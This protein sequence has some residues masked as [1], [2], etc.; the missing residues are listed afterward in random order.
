MMLITAEP[1][2]IKR[3]SESRAKMLEHIK[4]PTGRKLFRE[5]LMTKYCEENL[6]FI[7]AVDE[8]KAAKTDVEKQ[9]IAQDIYK[10]HLSPNAT[11]GLCLSPQ[12]EEIVY[13]CRTLAKPNTRTAGPI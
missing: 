4:L 10:T 12:W 9:R 6:D 11:A 2:S 8:L 5:F 7:L 3:P 13:V 1:F